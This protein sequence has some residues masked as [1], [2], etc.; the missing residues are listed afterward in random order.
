MMK[1][2]IILLLGLL[3]VNTAWG[4]NQ[5]DLKKIEAARIGLIS[6]RLGLTP[7]QAEKFWPLYN[8]YAEKRKEFR[9]EMSNARQNIDL[10]TATEQEKRNLIELGLKL[11]ER[12]AALE[13]TYSDRLLRVISSQQMLNLKK[14][15]DDFREMLLQRI[16]QRGPQRSEEQMRGKQQ[17]QINRRRNN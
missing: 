5:E 3:F 7:E 13:K 4:Q 15:E 14:A 2:Y 8:E 12:E 9:S 11:K 17:E 1:I 6:E 16:Q 10:N